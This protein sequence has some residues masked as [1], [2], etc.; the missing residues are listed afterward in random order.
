MSA[1]P[2]PQVLNPHTCWRN[3]QQ[4]VHTKHV[5]RSEDYCPEFLVL[6][7]NIVVSEPFHYDSD[8]LLTPTNLEEYF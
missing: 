4:I 1:N 3:I 7:Q 5:R 6:T 2:I 8:I